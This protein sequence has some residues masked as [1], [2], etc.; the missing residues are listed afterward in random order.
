MSRTID[1][2][3]E[4][5]A[6]PVHARRRRRSRR[7]GGCWPRRAACARPDRASSQA[8]TNSSI[9]TRVRRKLDRNDRRREA[10]LTR[11]ASSPAYCSLAKSGIEVGVADRPARR[12]RS[13]SRY[14]SRNRSSSGR[15]FCAIGC[16]SAQARKNSARKR[17]WKMSTKRGE[18]VVSFAQPVVRLFGRRQRQRALR[19]EHAEKSRLEADEAGRLDARG[20]DVRIGKLEIGILRRGRRIRRRACAR[21]RC[22]A[23]PDFRARAAAGRQAG[24]T[25]R[26]RRRVRRGRSRY[27]PEPDARRP[28]HDLAALGRAHDRLGEVVDRHVFG[29]EPVEDR[30]EEERAGAF[31]RLLFQRH[32]DLEPARRRGALRLPQTPDDRPRAEAAHAADLAVGRAVGEVGEQDER[33]AQRRRAVRR[34]GRRGR[35]D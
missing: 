33:L 17:R 6:D 34:R 16:A 1:A 10:L 32:G 30:A 24:R 7:R 27:A 11:G 26:A 18:R 19:A 8:P 2:D 23:C 13:S 29:E 15:S 22:A 3:A 31:E 35:D 9:S 25:A 20:L 4:L 28:A 21:R 5:V 14:R 12:C